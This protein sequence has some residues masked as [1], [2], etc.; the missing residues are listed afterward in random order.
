MVIQ[1]IDAEEYK[2][3]KKLSLD[4]T[5]TYERC[6]ALE[7]ITQMM[8][9][10]VMG[11]SYKQEIG[12]EQGD[13]LKWDDF[14]II[15]EDASKTYIQVKRQSTNFWSGVVGETV[16]RDKN[17]KGNMRE[18]TPFDETIEALSKVCQGET[19]NKNRFCIYLP[20]DSL[21]IKKDMTIRNL[22]NFMESI[23]PVTLGCDLER[24]AA[25]DQHT[26]NVVLWLQTWCGF[27]DYNQIVKAFQMLEIY[28][29][30][31]ET[32]IMNRVECNLKEIF[33]DTKVEVVRDRLSCYIDNNSTYAGAFRPRQLVFELK[34]YLRPEISLW[35]L[36]KADESSWIISG[37]NDLGSEDG[38][39]AATVVSSIWNNQSR[40]NL[41]IAGKYSEKCKLAKSLMRLSIHQNGVSFTSSSDK[42]L[43]IINL[44]KSVGETLGNDKN[45]CS[46]INILSL[47]EG[48]AD[49]NGKEIN[50]LCD[51]EQYAE[52]L[53]DAMYKITLKTVNTRILQ[54]IEN[55]EISELRNEIE[56]CWKCWFEKFNTD[57]TILKKIFMNILHPV[58]EGDSVSGEMRVGCKTVGLLTDAVFLTMVVCIAFGIGEKCKR[59]YL[60]DFLDIRVIGLKAWSGPAES[61][62]KVIE[63]EEETT[64]MLAQEREPIVILSGTKLPVSELLNE[65]LTGNS[66][67]S[68]LITDRKQPKLLIPYDRRMRRLINKGEIV[69]IKEYLQSQLDKY[70]IR[71]EETIKS[72]VGEKNEI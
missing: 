64:K 17:K 46:N 71:V 25:V 37:I 16:K 6:I 15:N 27:T 4:K 38:E 52:D 3:L 44:K 36:F 55:M 22:R 9:D 67:H 18:L 7:Q 32:D 19:H 11:R 39:T 66:A 47:D 51:K 28:T 61:L 29:T 1:N 14:V 10:F 35:T 70:D 40:S 31:Y 26:N 24:Q 56:K 48:I 45:D 30:G 68:G 53:N 2:M 21:Y 43:W 5:K 65:D 54:E 57:R 8:C 58:C 62:K 60:N 42:N 59:Y 50:F 12:A 63:I 41:K 33:M 20:S 72:I 34:E 49:I 69:E 13:I 23:K